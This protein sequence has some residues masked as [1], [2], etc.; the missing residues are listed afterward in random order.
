MNMK[1]IIAC[2][3][4][5][6]EMRFSHQRLQQLPETIR[7]PDLATAYQVQDALVDRLLARHGGRRIGYKAACT[8]ALAQQQLNVP[9]PLFGQMLSFSHL[10]SPATL[11][12]D[13]F[14]LRIV[15][16]EF[17]VQMAQDVPARVQAYSASE[18]AA[19]VGAVMPGIE[20]VSHRFVNWAKVGAPS[21]AADNAIHGAWVQGAPIADWQA[22]DLAAQPVTL[23][24]NGKF[25]ERGS[26]ANVLGHPLNVVAWL[27][28]EL[29][30]HGKQLK[31]GNFITTG[32][33]MNVYLAQAGD[34]LRA[35]FGALG[36]VEVTFVD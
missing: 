19:F 15:E 1:Q 12:A 32:V 25:F 27:A 4:L 29:P 17:G 11:R 36:T 14:T 33:V 31:T 13:D 3:E 9:G 24:V 5:L 21:V 7:P 16:A 26:G 35:D 23:T 30:Q 6:A 8:N 34:H 10:H 22:F 20:I 2:A 18:I 28:S